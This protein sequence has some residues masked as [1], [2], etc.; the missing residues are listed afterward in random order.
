MWYPE[1]PS[2]SRWS[3]P[4]VFI[5]GLVVGVILGWLFQGIIGTL[6]RFALLA[7]LIAGIVFFLNVW[8]KSKSPDTDP[9]DDMP[10]ADWRD[11]SSRRRR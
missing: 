8:R 5:A 10:E 11:L 1:S 9:F 7:L 4:Y 6:V 3:T 2:S